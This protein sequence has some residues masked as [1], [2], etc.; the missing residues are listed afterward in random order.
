MNAIVVKKLPERAIWHIY[1]QSATKL[2][3]GR[4]AYASEA[5]ALEAAK[6]MYPGRTI[7]VQRGE[8]RVAIK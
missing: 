4:T 1:Q 3:A 5:S 2:A 8:Q 6:E 7:Y